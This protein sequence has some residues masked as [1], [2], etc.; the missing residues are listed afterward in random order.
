MIE[1]ATEP[2]ALWMRETPAP[3]TAPELRA[4]RFEYS[5]RG[6]RVPGVLLLPPAGPGPFPLVLLQHGAGGSK[7]AA[8]LPPVREP[9]ARRG[10][11]V[12]SIDFPLHG[13]RSSAKLNEILLATMLAPQR[14][15]GDGLALFEELVRQAVND[16]ARAVDALG[17]LPEI[18]ADRVGY[19]AF[20]M[21]AMLGSLY[22]PY[23]ARI[24]AAALGVGGSLFGS[25]PLDPASHIAG[26]AP[27]PLL[28]VNASR[29]ERISRSA[30]EALHA[31]A[32]DPKE[33]VW[34]DA[35]HS[36]LPGR[37]LKAMWTFLAQHLG[38][39]A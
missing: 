27:R 1:A 24:R 22:I 30:A 26:F 28:F 39:A 32:R 31:A 8:Y 17:A 20:S 38:V 25:S 29:D 16:L 14:A 11:A 6:D 15:G 34:F 2:T 18:D 3:A 7:D 33:V 4:R 37:A 36:D 5:S 9:W 23:D 12:A 19:A 13:E 21:G 10:V 35:G